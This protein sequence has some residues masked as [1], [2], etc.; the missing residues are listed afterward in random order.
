MNSIYLSQEQPR[1]TPETESDIT[2]AITQGLLEETH[3]LDLKREL[4]SGRAENRELARDLAQFAIDGGA[5]LVGVEEVKG[6]APR[7]APVALDG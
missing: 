5:L 7:L 3:F 6:G 2:S 1:W 4:G